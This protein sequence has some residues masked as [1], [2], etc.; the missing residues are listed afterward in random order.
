MGSRGVGL[1]K[2]GKT[3]KLSRPKGKVLGKKFVQGMEDVLDKYGTDLAKQVFSKFLGEMTFGGDAPA[4]EAHYSPKNKHVRF[5]I[6]ETVK[7]DAVY[8]PYEVAFH[9]FGHAIDHT[10]NTK[11][12]LQSHSAQMDLRASKLRDYNNYKKKMGFKSDD[13]VFNHFKKNFSLHSRAALS[14]ALEGVTLRDYPLSVGHGASYHAA[15]FMSGKEF[16]ASVLQTQA[17]NPA[18]YK[19]LK[20]VFPKSVAMVE[21]SVKKMIEEAGN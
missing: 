12:G 18:G 14:D 20:E 21:K 17:A 15:G 7:G 19:L 3:G 6:K 2:T 11:F 13:E 9:E 1:G 10:K 4:G 8:G 5:N 16:Y